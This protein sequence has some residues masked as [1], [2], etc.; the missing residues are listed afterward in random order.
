MPQ[1]QK[2]L[3]KLPNPELNPLLNPTLGNNLGRWAQAYFTSPPEKREEAV[4]DLL[5]ELESEAGSG[6]ATQINSGADPSWLHALESS[7]LNPALT[8]AECGHKNA[9]QQ[10]FC[11]MCGSR[12]V[13]SDPPVEADSSI[14]LAQTPAPAELSSQNFGSQSVPSFG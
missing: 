8:C 5:H 4:L 2:P 3:Q 6:G 7:E 11:G 13:F 10:R 14:H 1:S 9:P 12:L